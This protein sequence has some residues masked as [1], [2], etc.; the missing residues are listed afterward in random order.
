MKYNIIKGSL[1]QIALS[2]NQPLAK[3]LLKV[4]CVI[5][6]DVS[7]SMDDRD[8]KTG[9]T[10]YTTA[11]KELETLQGQLAGRI[12]LIAF[13]DTPSFCPQGTP[14][15]PKGLTNLAKALEFAKTFDVTG[16][17]FILISDGQ[18]NSEAEALKVA[19][20]YKNRIDVIFVGQKGSKGEKFLQ[21]LANAR[22]GQSMTADTFVGL[23][24]TIHR[25]LTVSA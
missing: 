24:P 16:V 1:A 2:T 18:P 4:D 23:Y 19:Q 13:N 20:T 25:L 12:A 22:N 8:Q 11:C 10:Y 3:V 15:K 9:E 5:I 6:I 14:P 17:R 21:E 7:A